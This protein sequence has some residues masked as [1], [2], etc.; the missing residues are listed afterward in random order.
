MAEYYPLYV[1]NLQVSAIFLE[2]HEEVSEAQFACEVAGGQPGMKPWNPVVVAR[3]NSRVPIAHLP[4]P[5]NSKP[6][7]LHRVVI[8]ILCILCLVP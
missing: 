8:V 3:S 2:C 5:T 4:C 1:G 6:H 7:T